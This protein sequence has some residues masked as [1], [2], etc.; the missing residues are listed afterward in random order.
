MINDHIYPDQPISFGYKCSW[1]AIKA[2]DPQDVIKVLGL[3]NVRRSN[4]K[5]GIDAAY[6]GEVFIAPPLD[7]WIL[8]LS[9]NFPWP[10]GVRLGDPCT[11]FL[12]QLAYTFSE[13][14]FFATHRIVETHAWARLVDGMIVRQYAYSGESAEI[15]WN[16]GTPTAE[17]RVLLQEQ[18][19]WIQSFGEPEHDDDIVSDDQVHLMPSESDVMRIAA[20]WS[21]DPSQL[22]ER[23]LGTSLGHVGALDQTQLAQWTG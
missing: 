14:Q 13:V 16:V 18:E 23:G 9:W 17:E 21:I 12:L 10:G 22:S 6:A 8:A 2:D 4:W 15:L 11:P 5:A 3:R 19:E 20:V 7:G 1:L